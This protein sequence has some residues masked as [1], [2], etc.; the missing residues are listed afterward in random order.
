MK[1]ANYIYDIYVYISIYYSTACHI[2]LKCR[3]YNTIQAL[4]FTR[5]FPSFFFNN[6]SLSLQCLS[7]LSL[8]L[9]TLCLPSCLHRDPFPLR[10][11]FCF[12]NIYS[13]SFSSCA[14]QNCILYWT[15]KNCGVPSTEY[16]AGSDVLHWL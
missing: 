5:S 13:I 8:S 15:N 2:I 11:Y 3:Y 12:D 9:C 16:F 7:S 6:K 14:Q 1:T 10:K 4:L